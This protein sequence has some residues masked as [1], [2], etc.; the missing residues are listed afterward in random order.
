[1]IILWRNRPARV[2]TPVP[3]ATARRVP[4]PRPHRTNPGWPPWV[5][6]RRGPALDRLGDG[7]PPTGRGRSQ[8]T[9]TRRIAGVGPGHGTRSL[10]SWRTCRRRSGTRTR[11]P[12]CHRPPSP[13]RTDG[14]PRTGP[15]HS[16]ALRATRRVRRRP[17]PIRSVRRRRSTDRRSPGRTS[18]AVELERAA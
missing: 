14:T 4:R 7:A 15:T 11:A 12:R 3:T 10:P 6:G 18:N 5:R 8:Q 13:P 16:S 2:G 17:P 1:M 9:R